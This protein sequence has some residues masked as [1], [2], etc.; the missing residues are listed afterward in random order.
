MK[1]LFFPVNYCPFYVVVL[2]TSICLTFHS[3]QTEKDQLAQ[4]K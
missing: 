3:K 2:S 1:F 4:I